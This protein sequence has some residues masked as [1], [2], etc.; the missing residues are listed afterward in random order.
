[1]IFAAL[2]TEKTESLTFGACGYPARVTVS[3]AVHTGLFGHLHLDIH[4]HKSLCQHQVVPSQC[5]VPEWA[6]G[7]AS[8]LQFRVHCSLHNKRFEQHFLS[9]ICDKK[10]VHTKTAKRQA[11]SVQVKSRLETET[12]DTQCSNLSFSP[13]SGPILRTSLVHFMLWTRCIQPWRLDAV[14]GAINCANKCVLRLHKSS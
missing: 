13:S 8:P 14:M 11:P 4:V 2:T 12:T 10:R 5:F 6:V 1:M 9:I 7:F 3:P